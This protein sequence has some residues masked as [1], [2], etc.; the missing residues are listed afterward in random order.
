MPVAFGCLKKFSVWDGSEETYCEV[1]TEVT[2]IVAGVRHILNLVDPTFYLNHLKILQKPALIKA[3]RI[4]IGYGIGLSTA[5]LP[6]CLALCL[7]RIQGSQQIPV[8]RYMELLFLFIFSAHPFLCMT[9]AYFTH[10]D[11]SG[12]QPYLEVL[13]SKSIFKSP[14]SK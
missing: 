10:R 14:F 3:N 2:L 4:H 11:K 12:F 8:A 5:V 9:D 13:Y 1:T 7:A 6:N